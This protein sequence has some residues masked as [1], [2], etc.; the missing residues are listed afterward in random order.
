MSVHQI[1]DETCISS[2]FSSRSS[3]LQKKISFV[4]AEALLAALSIYKFG[5]FG[6]LAGETKTKGRPED[7]GSFVEL[8]E[9]NLNFRTGRVNGIENRHLL[10]I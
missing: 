5:Q 1:D 2:G 8:F 3:F 6:R 10:F 4:G 7:T 9:Q